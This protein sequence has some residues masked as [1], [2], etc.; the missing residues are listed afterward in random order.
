MGNSFC[1]IFKNYLFY[2]ILTSLIILSVLVGINI[3][4]SFLY[5]FLI[6]KFL[7]DYFYLKYILILILFLSNYLF[8]RRNI[9]HCLFVWQYPF[10]CFSIYRERQNFVSDLKEKVTEFLDSLEVLLNSQYILTQNEI[11]SISSFFDLFDEQFYIY[12]NLYNTVY[13]NNG[14]HNNN[15]IR[16]KMSNKQIKYY[17]ILKAMNNI[18]NEND[19]RDKLKN[20]NLDSNKFLNANKIENQ[21]DNIPKLTQLKIL[22]NNELLPIIE[23]YDWDNYTFM[24]P[25]YIFNSIFNDTFGSLSL[26]SFLFKKNFQDYSLEENYSSNGKIHYTLIRNLKSI[27]NDNKANEIDDI[28]TEENLLIKEKEKQDDG[29]LIFFSLPNG[30]CYELIPKSK[31]EFY[32]IHGFSFLCW[33]YRGYGHSKGS[34]NFSNCKEDAL[35][36]F[37]T[38]TKSKKYNFKK[39]C[40]M[41]HSIG[42]VPTSY[43]AKNRNV[44]MSILDR[45]FCDLPRITLNFH[46][47]NILSFLLKFFLI[48]NTNIIEN[49]MEE[50]KKNNLNDQNMNNINKIIVYSPYDHLVANDGTVKS[51]I[52]R[53]FIKNYISYKN[54]ENIVIKSKENFLDLIFNSNEKNLFLNNLINLIHMNHDLPQNLNDKKNIIKNDNIIDDENENISNEKEDIS[55]LFFDKFFGIC[56]DNLSYIAEK[57]LSIRRQKIF[58]DNFFNNLLIWGAQGEMIYPDEEIFE[59]YSYKGLKLIKEACDILNKNKLDE[60]LDINE[61]D[62]LLARKSLILDSLRICFEK[63]LSVMQNLEIIDKSNDVKN[64]ILKINNLDDE[65]IKEKLIMTDDDQEEINTNNT[66]DN[67]GIINTKI[68]NTNDILIDRD[69]FKENKFYQQLNKI[70]GN[71]KLFRTNVGHNGPFRKDENEQFFLLLLKSRIID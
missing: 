62:N 58:L 50:Q 44:D 64:N 51:G 48:G 27:N 34:C 69:I 18:F 16:Y 55:F 8:F 40:V 31:I 71:F 32:L 10:Q 24:S 6:E 17:N 5:F 52:S 4:I 30:G 2:I 49:I 36:V 42:G 25:A 22:I 19:F 15:L 43:I 35:D 14:I 37:D 23:D 65:N 41:G 9:I 29:T 3:G 13:A 68:E 63:I 21:E 39:I 70:T 46:C 38:I 1:S 20:L 60:N 28:N 26:Y 54:P 59:Y 7:P 33:N 56:C 11:I 53:Y 45:S 47:G 61:K 66:N 57:E 12:D 67:K